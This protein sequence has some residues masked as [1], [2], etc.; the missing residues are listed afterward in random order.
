MAEYHWVVIRQGVAP[1][2]GDKPQPFQMNGP[3]FKLGA[4]L[5]DDEAAH[6]QEM[7]HST[8]IRRVAMGAH[9]SRSADGTHNL[10]D[11]TQVAPLPKQADAPVDAPP[12]QPV[13]EVPQVQPATVA[14]PVAAVAPATKPLPG[15]APT[16]AAPVPAIAPPAATPPQPP[17]PPAAVK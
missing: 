16:T 5:T 6:L 8:K 11:G 4:V 13:V 2:D 7:P 3:F 17:P 14:S 1:A 15:A 10:P 9:P 12:T